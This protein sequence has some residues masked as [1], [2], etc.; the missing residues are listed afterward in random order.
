MVNQSLNMTLFAVDYLVNNA[1]IVA[2]S[3]FED[4]TDITKFAPAMVMN[5]SILTHLC[6][7][8][9]GIDREHFQFITFR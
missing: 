6:S 8:L 3:L 5:L 2:L 1:G 9:R 7:W 4:T